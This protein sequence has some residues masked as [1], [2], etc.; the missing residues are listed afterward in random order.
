MVSTSARSGRVLWPALVL[1]LVLLTDAPV[2]AAVDVSGFSSRSGATVEVEDHPEGS[3]VR[4]EW[5]LGEGERGRLVLDTRPGKSL[6]ERLEIVPEG[7][8]AVPLV[9]EADPATF[10][11]VGSRVAPAGRP[12]AMSPFNVF[13]DSPA[14]RPHESYRAK[15]DIKGV[16]V[17]SQGRQATVI[18]DGLT[19]GPFTGSLYL[20]VYPGSRLLHVE[21]GLRTSEDLRAYLYD[22]G[23]VSAA[24]AWKRFV[25]T[26][27]EGQLE[28][29]EARADAAD[30]PHAVR[31][32]TIVAESEGGS[33]A[34]FPPPHRF[35][36][37]RD[38][39]DNLSTVW[40][41]RDHRGLEPRAGFG[42]RQPETGGGGF[43]PWFNAPPGTEQKMGVFY[44]LARGGAE[45]ALRETL[46]YTH[47]DRFPELP[48]HST[49]TSHWHM[50]IA[51]AAM[52]EQARGKTRST[53]DF[54][55]MFKDMGVNLVHLAEFHGDGHQFDAG[56]L[57]LPELDAMFAECRRLS[58]DRLVLLPGEEVNTYLGIASPGRHPGHWMSLFPR[59]VYWTIKREPG[60]AFVERDPKR[61]MVY[62][63]GSREDM[64]HLLE[65]EHGLVWSAHPRIKASSWAPDA[66]RDQDFYRADFWLG[67][68]WKG[69]PAD[70]SEPRLGRRAL[71]LLDDM[72]NW[73]SEKY[74]PGE[75]DVFKLDHTHELYGHMNINYLR[76]DRLPRFDEGW[77]P[78]LDALR[79]GR[80]F[81]TT[82]EVL[83]REFSLGGKSS[84]ETVALAS[85]DEPELRLDLEWTFPL[86]FVEIVSGDGTNVF[87][88]RLDFSDTESFGRRTLTHR[89]SL[90]GRKWLRVE[91]WD[92]AGNGAFSQ[93]IWVDSRKP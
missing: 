44:L 4:L 5:P 31:H 63:V 12:P 69:M 91:A 30:R 3:V 13:F 53:P 36:T 9:K 17:V 15:L 40:S 68:A 57:R 39:T 73:G 72:A 81:V 59:P 43:V 14:K 21:A 7:A 77:Q 46:R 32:R 47:G 18:L 75:V 24:P 87:H 48:G 38:L 79:A 52:Q 71:D 1:G 65:T 11:T 51:V 29:Q 22:A 50:A 89:P 82:G 93:P 49:F 90:L 60:A 86:R 83:L 33:L 70:L 74:M 19:A 8:G 20:S 35:F 10:V 62:H 78:V 92:V 37:P 42:I 61:G 54:V 25:W 16:R 84:G 55:R 45:D 6:I 56:P 28:R 58:D 41:G 23:L 26:G 80:F 27:T 88:E 64:V 67:A 66:F 76:L 2:R 85:S 34:C